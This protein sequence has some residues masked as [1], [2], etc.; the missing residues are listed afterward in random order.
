MAPNKSPTSKTQDARAPPTANAPEGFIQRAIESTAQWG[1]GG[2][3]TPGKA[4]RWAS[5]VSGRAYC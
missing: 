1:R 5:R 3:E 4:S 2:T